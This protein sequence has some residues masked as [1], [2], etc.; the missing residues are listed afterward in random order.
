MPEQKDCSEYFTRTAQNHNV[1]WTVHPG[2]FGEKGK[3][4]N[5]TE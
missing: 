2:M 4:G 3:E 5:Q 1:K